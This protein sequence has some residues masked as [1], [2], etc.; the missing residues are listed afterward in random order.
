MAVRPP[1][2]AELAAIA[3]RLNLTLDEADVES[4][5]GLIEGSLVSYEKVDELLGAPAVAP[6]RESWRPGSSENPL[7][8]WYY[9]TSIT[10]GATGPLSGKRIVIKDNT[11]V[12]GV[13]MM[14]GSAS[15][16]GYV[17]AQDAAVVQRLLDAGAE[18]VGKAVCEDLC[19]SGGSHTPHTGPVLNPWRP[20]HSA[21]G[22][23]GGSAALVAAGEVDLAIGG[24]QGGSVRIPSAFCGTVGIKPTWGLVPYTGAFPIESTLDHL[25]PIGANVT[26]VATMLQVIAGADGNDPRQHPETVAGDYLTDLDGGVEG[27]RVGL[28]VEGFGWEGLSDP[29]VDEAVHV[30]A[31][32]LEEAGASVSEVSVPMHRDGIHIWNVISVEGA[33]TQMINLNSAGMNVKGLYDPALVEAF[34][35]GRLE[36]A[37]KLSDT[38]KFVALLGEHMIDTYG[39]AYYA[40][41]QNLAPQ[42]DAAYE[43]A[44]AEFDVL[45]MPTLPITATE[46][47]A[48]D[49]PRE[50]KM[51]RALE[52]ICNT[53]PF[54]V[55]GHP[56]LSVPVELVDGLPASMM[57]VAKQFDEATA[58]RVGRAYE[59]IIG[60]F[61]LASEGAAG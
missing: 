44:L 34:A 5:L 54:D 37:D 28:V 40:K 60:G 39:G 22:S 49:A 43:E 36:H 30:A 17:P 10:T 31:R 7:N 4:F 56:A 21:G 59:R 25:G 24:D 3:E 45:V 48:P 52:H 35:K 16:E 14:N 20:T 50:D 19:F 58:L 11:A 1:T 6:E 42:L 38:V 12:A 41:A 33:T 61:P 8:A 18:I 51:A 13:P 27:L 26:D 53:A 2:P 47:P 57:I 46:I 32:R 15:L 9:R 29:A 23:S 55:T